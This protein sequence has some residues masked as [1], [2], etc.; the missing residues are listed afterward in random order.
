VS[1][2]VFVGVDVPVDVPVG[3]DVLVDVPVAV[4][5]DVF[6][7]VAPPGVEVVTISCGA[8]PAVPSFD[9]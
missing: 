1:V 9:A 6:V 8:K 3:V 7:G 4:A 2:A 5:V